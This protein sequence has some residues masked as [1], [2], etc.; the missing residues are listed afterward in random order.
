MRVLVFGSRNWTDY[1][2]VLKGLRAELAKGPIELVID[3]QAPGADTCG[4]EAAVELGLPFQRFPANWSKYGR[5]AGP[6]RNQQML[7]EGKPTLA[8]GFHEDIA[9]SKGSADMLRRLK[10]YGI[11]T[12]I[13]GVLA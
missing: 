3:G 8:L 12:R 4:H 13:N 11:K 5:A 9:N 7:D 2:A 1:Q 6:I 10:R